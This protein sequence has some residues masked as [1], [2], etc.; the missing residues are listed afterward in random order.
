MV[1]R[2]RSTRRKVL[3]ALGAG[4]TVGL[5]G[6]AGGD[7]GGQGDGDAN[8]TTTTADNGGGNGDTTTQEGEWPDLSGKEVRFINGETAPE[9][10]TFWEKTLKPSFEKATGAK[11]ILDY[12]GR[13]VAPLQRISQLI[14]AGDP[15]EI[16]L[17]TGREVGLFH[18]QNQLVP[19]TD[20][21]SRVT[22]NLGP[23]KTNTRIQ[24]GGE[25]WQVP[26]F[27]YGVTQYVRTDVVDWRPE[28]WGEFM[29]WLGEADGVGGRH[30]GFVPAGPGPQRY[31]FPTMAWNRGLELVTYNGEKWVVN[32]NDGS[33]REKA[34]KTLNELKEHH[35]YGPTATDAGFGEW[36]NAVA[37][38]VSNSTGYIGLRPV[39]K[40]FRQE[41]DFAKH[42]KPVVGG[43]YPTQKDG[44]EKTAVGVLK[45]WGVFK[46][47]NV[48][49]AKTFIEYTMTE[50]ATEM[51]LSVDPAHHAPAYKEI[52]GS[53]EYMNG[54]QNKFDSLGWNVD[55]EVIKTY[56]KAPFQ[57]AVF[58]LTD[59]L[60]PYAQ[61]SYS[62][63]PFTNMVRSV[64]VRGTSPSESIDQYASQHQAQ[65]DKAQSK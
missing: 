52:L 33:A 49:A 24:I 13:D 9:A 56:Q 37:A 5:A 3:K 65:L 22:D 11:L 19:V 15:P 64:L 53:E 63:E 25:D 51:M 60:N 50:H 10:R 34:V 28:T 44:P 12:V 8:T 32:Y 47:S 57:S 16:F 48:D 41:R 20:L 1:A 38:G 31:Q 59:R 43:G 23:T 17:M 62:A 58:G 35:S 54:L 46:G 21:L 6:C 29:E 40:A 45:G 2:D 27:A 7:D 14:Q 55:M 61:Q 42:L 18:S 39:L 4:G 30:G 36:S 26:T